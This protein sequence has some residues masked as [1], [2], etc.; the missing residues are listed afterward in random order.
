[1]DYELRVL[2]GLHRG[3]CL[4]LGPDEK[5]RLGSASD[6]DVV[7]LDQGLQ[8]QEW[9]VWRGKDKWYAAKCDKLGKPT[10]E[11]RLSWGQPEALGSV[12]ITICEASAAWTFVSAEQ[13][14]IPADVDASGKT[15]KSSA[16]DDPETGAK[17]KA[18]KRFKNLHRGILAGT[19][20]LGVATFS[21]SRTVSSDEEPPKITRSKSPTPKA[22]LAPKF[23]S[24]ASYQV[25]PDGLPAPLLGTAEAFSPAKLSSLLKQRLADVDLADKLELDLS[26]REWIIRGSLDEDEQRQVQRVTANFYKEYQVSIPL[27]L[28]VNSPE[29]LLP[30][31]IVQ[32]NGGPLASVVLDDGSRIYVGDMHKGYALQSIDGRKVTFTGKRKVEVI[33]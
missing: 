16:V 27:K 22:A 25:A 26:D 1:M 17:R 23:E 9:V 4:P 3:A 28:S 11:E 10:T 24:L 20:V 15:L 14:A 21:I 33:W 8:G 6:C 12:V 31:K 2:S 32:F 19:M 13:I 5:L 30:F 7:L 18:P 29:E